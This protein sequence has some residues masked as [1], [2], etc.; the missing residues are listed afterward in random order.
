MPGEYLNISFK[1]EYCVLNRKVSLSVRS[2][3]ILIKM[4]HTYISR[5]YL[6]WIPVF[7]RN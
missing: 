1:K 7:L 4:V 2:V 5:G 3:M 6:G